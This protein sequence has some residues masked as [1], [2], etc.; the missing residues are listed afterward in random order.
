[1]PPVVAEEFLMFI[2]EGMTQ[3]PDDLFP[4]LLPKFPIPKILRGSNHSLL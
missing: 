2:Q 4:I 3:S 1:M